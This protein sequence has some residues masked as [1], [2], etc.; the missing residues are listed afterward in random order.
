MGELY[1]ITEVS[2]MTGLSRYRLQ[3]I[4]DE[5]GFCLIDQKISRADLD[6]ILS[7]RQSYISLYEYA[8]AKSSIHFDGEKSS[9]R[10]KLYDFMLANN[11]W[12]LDV[13]L[14]EDLITGTKLDLIFFYRSNVKFLDTKTSAFFKDFGV[15]E[16][17]LIMQ[18]INSTRKHETTLKYLRTFLSVHLQTN[19]ATKATTDFVNLILSIPD[20]L[21]IQN[22]HIG[23]IIREATTI[24]TRDLIIKFLNYVKEHEPVRYGSFFVKKVDDKEV[25]NPAYTNEEY[26]ALSKFFFNSDYIAEHDMIR[27]ALDY[28]IFAEMWLFLCLF[29]VCGWRAADVTRNW[30]YPE[31]YK[32]KRSFA[33]INIESLPDDLLNHRIP[34]ESCRAVCMSSIL[35]IDLANSFASKNFGDTLQPLS[36]FI[37][38]E[39]QVFFGQLTLLGEC[40]RLHSNDGYMQENRIETYRNKMKLRAFFGDEIYSVLN[41]ENISP[42]RLTKTLLQGIQLEG[43][44]MGL[45]GVQTSM[46]AAYARNHTGL[47]SISHYLKDG[48][49]T[50]ETPEMVLYCMMERGVFGVQIYQTLLNAYPEGMLALS[51]KKQTELIK[52]LKSSPLKIENEQTG[53]VTQRRIEDTFKAGNTSESLELLQNM[54]VISQQRGKGKDDGIYCLNRVRG[55]ACPFPEFESCFICC[56]EELVFTRYGLLPLIN[57][58]NDFYT[59]SLT[60]DKKAMA[61]LHDILIPRYQN[62]LNQLLET[63]SLSQQERIGIKRLIERNLLVLHK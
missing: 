39:L 27:K 56:C 51:S 34:E 19:S 26:I 33:G 21:T 32:K 25:R 37:P 17:T 40:H 61:I 49:L 46:L 7:E 42:T 10:N 13:I 44:K 28:H 55:K 45:N 31:L 23:Q 24:K 3:C 54:L 59:Q 29:F 36:V 53:L 52:M 62:I 38:P 5:N 47:Y 6:R 41:R 11:F 60:G 48:K 30:Q 14:P 15:S 2:K 18:R 9:Y 16:E 43:K 1:S 20:V 8:I 12:G 63:S 22:S 4:I 57:V 58:L 50:Q 35:K